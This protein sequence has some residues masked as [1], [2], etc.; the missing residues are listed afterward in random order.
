MPA[1]VCGWSRVAISLSRKFW[2]GPQAY[3]LQNTDKRVIF[4]NPYE[5]DLALIGTTDIA[6]EGRAEDVVADQD[7]I[8]YLIGVVNRYMRH[9]LDCGRH[10][11]QLFRRPSAL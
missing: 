10:P 9:E 4:I 8:A 3:L 7:E 5:D 1:G 6:Y 11:P 2:D